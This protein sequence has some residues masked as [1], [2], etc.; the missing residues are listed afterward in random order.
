[1]KYFKENESIATDPQ[2]IA[3]AAKHM[4]EA[5][6]PAEEWNENKMGI[7]LMLATELYMKEAALEER[8]AKLDELETKIKNQLS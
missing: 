6:M 4:K 8:A 7:L 3:S 1:M 5:G 2:F